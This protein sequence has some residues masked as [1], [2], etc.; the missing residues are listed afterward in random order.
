MR[1]HSDP[2]A[3]NPQKQSPPPVQHFWTWAIQHEPNTPPDNASYLIKK[4]MRTGTTRHIHLHLNK[5]FRRMSDDG[6]R[7]KPDRVWINR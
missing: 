7:P 5:P 1:V 6:S 2:R 3:K 4:R